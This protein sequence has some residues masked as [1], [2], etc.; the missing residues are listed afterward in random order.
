MYKN[1]VFG[2]LAHVSSVEVGILNPVG[3]AH[4]VGAFILYKLHGSP[5]FLKWFLLGRHS[6][7]HTIH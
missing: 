4:N 3:Q 7:K 1:G 2:A 6:L 5:G